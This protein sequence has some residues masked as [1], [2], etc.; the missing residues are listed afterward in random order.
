MRIWTLSG[1]YLGTVGTFK[2]WTPLKYHEPVG[3]DHPYMPMPP[4]IAR[5]ASST[6]YKV[7]LF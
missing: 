6:T 1:R 3:A 2:P 4:D 5:V 7:F